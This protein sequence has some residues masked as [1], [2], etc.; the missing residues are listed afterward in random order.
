MISELT[1]APIYG[2]QTN[3]I[4][5]SNLLAL[6]FINKWEVVL[7]K[8]RCTQIEFAFPHNTPPLVTLP[9]TKV[10]KAAYS[11]MV[12]TYANNYKTNEVDLKLQYDTI[13]CTI[14]W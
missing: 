13:L 11:I 10:Y 8:H 4:I 6:I 7:V 9:Y 2:M 1:H 5:T 14:F 3:F 12:I